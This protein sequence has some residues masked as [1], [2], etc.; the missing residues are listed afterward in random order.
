MAVETVLGIIY[1]TPPSDIVFGEFSGTPNRYKISINGTET[2]ERQNIAGTIA[3]VTN[4]FVRGRDYHIEIT[5]Q[6]LGQNFFGG[7]AY[8]DGQSSAIDVRAPLA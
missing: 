8:F 2:Y 5:P 7:P 3:Q 4:L 6:W 1:W